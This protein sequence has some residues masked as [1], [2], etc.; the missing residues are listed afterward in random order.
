[1]ST[2]SRDARMPRAP[3]RRDARPAALSL[4]EARARVLVAQGFG[5]PRPQ[6]TVGLD[7]VRQTVDRLGLLQLDSVQVLVRAHYLP[8]FSRLGPYERDLLDRLAYRDRELFEYWG[9]EASLLPV[10]LQP[11]LR[12]RMDRK[13]WAAVAALL[14]TQPDAGRRCSVAS[15]RRDPSRR[16]T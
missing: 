2:S 10:R 3:V 13:P 9:H 16:P 15:T 11:L 14:R 4:A 8:L 7:H 12:W 6:G 5:D 1:M